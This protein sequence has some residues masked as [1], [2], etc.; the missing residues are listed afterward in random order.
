MTDSKTH[1]WCACCDPAPDRSR[2]RLLRAALGAPFAAAAGPVFAAAGAMPRSGNFV[3]RGASLVTMDPTLG[4]LARGDVH[5]RDG[6]IVAVAPRVD[7]PDA[8]IVDAGGMVAMPGF[9]ETHWHLW[10]SLLKN[11]LRPGAEY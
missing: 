2:R 10:N 11:M 7:A 5:V 6:R 1:W 8:E 4:D 3:L 9:V